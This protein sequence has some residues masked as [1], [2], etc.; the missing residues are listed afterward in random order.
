[1]G[2]I[3][4]RVTKKRKR[5]LKHP[6]SFFAILFRIS[7]PRRRRA[8]RSRMLA[9]SKWPEWSFLI[10]GVAPSANFEVSF[11]ERTKWHTTATVVTNKK[12]LQK[13]C[14]FLF[15]N[16]AFRAY[17]PFSPRSHSHFA[18]SLKLT[19]EIP[20]FAGYR[21]EGILSTYKKSAP[22]RFLLFIYK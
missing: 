17:D 14:F 10:S 6:F 8:V 19:S 4:V 21:G 7:N 13:K 5:M 18:R 9:R 12:A 20:C 16:L 15:S 3:P 2:S 22:R 1:M 11:S